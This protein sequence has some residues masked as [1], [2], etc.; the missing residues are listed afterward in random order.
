MS[1]IIKYK[2]SSPCYGLRGTQY[3]SPS[4]NSQTTPDQIQAFL[5]AKSLSLLMTE[6]TPAWEVF[7]LTPS[8]M[9]FMGSFLQNSELKHVVKG[10]YGR[11]SK[12]AQ[13]P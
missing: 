2:L 1:P 9:I 4:Y 12:D 11:L 10:E 13:I 5:W 6:W 7:I 3:L 8:K